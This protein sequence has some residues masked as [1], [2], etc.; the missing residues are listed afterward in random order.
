MLDC[1]F[2]VIPLCARDPPFAQQGY[3]FIVVGAFFDDVASAED[4]LYAVIYKERQ[5]LLQRIHIAVNVRQNTDL[6]GW[7]RL[8]AEDAKDDDRIGTTLRRRWF[9]VI[10]QHH[11]QYVIRQSFEKRNEIVFL[12]L[13]HIE[14]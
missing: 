2:V 13:C 11:R 5:R 14:A 7:R 4:R 6:H 1:V 10:F 3:D 12:L 9:A 8:L